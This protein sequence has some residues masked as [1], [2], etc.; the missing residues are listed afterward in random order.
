[1]I[2]ASNAGTIAGKE[3]ACLKASLFKREWS[4]SRVEMFSDGSDLES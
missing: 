4:I 2:K 3:Q 1:M